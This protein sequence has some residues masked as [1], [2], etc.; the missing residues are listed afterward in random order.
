MHAVGLKQ[1]EELPDPSHREVKKAEDYGGVEGKNEAPQ[2]AAINKYLDKEQDYE[3]KVDEA[4]DA[5]KAAFSVA[6]RLDVRHSSCSEHG[7]KKYSNLEIAQHK[8]PV[9]K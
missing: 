3:G 6:A 4:I 7:P 2:Y 1:S 9:R 5:V 8:H